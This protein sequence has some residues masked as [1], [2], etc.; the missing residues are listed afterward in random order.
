MD[1][2]HTS[3]QPYRFTLSLKSF[4]SLIFLYRIR[5]RYRDTGKKVQDELKSLI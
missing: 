1:I 5:Q 2:M 3:V 4:A